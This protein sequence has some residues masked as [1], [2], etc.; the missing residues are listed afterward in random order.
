MSIIKTVFFSLPMILIVGCTSS[1]EQLTTAGA[2]VAVRDG[3]PDNR[4]QL[5]GK[6][7]A[8]QQNW[9]SNHTDP[10]SQAEIKLRNQ[11]ATLNANA[12]Y[13]VTYLSDSLI[14]QFYPA[15]TKITADAYR[16]DY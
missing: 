1:V 10:A 8:S 12:L 7:T 3:Q 13:N 4:C 14:D 9:V 6:V 16:C 2:S 5:V 11:A 15:P